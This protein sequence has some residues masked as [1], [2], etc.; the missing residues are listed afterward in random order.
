MDELMYNY[1]NKEPVARSLHYCEK[2]NELDRSRQ[3]IGFLKAAHSYELDP[4][5]IFAID[6]EI[7]AIEID[8][9][10]AAGRILIDYLLNFFVGI[11]LRVQSE[12]DDMLLCWPLLADDRPNDA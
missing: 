9:G 1:F 10:T 7:A 3:L 4:T 8:L 5:M 6:Q 12:I 11:S 2:L